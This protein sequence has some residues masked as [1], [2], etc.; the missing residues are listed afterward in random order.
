M[1]RRLTCV[2]DATKGPE[3]GGAPADDE[4]SSGED[5]VETAERVAAEAT[6]SNDDARQDRPALT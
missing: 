2:A 4:R 6:P 1:L 3:S 5:A